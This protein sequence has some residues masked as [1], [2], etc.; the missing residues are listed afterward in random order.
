MCCIAALTLVFVLAILENFIPLSVLINLLFA[1][2]II[3][4]VGLLSFKVGLCVYCQM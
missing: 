1:M 4:P 3:R 2:Y